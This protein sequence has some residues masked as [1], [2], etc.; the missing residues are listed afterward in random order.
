MDAL[1]TD[2]SNS[3]TSRDTDPLNGPD[4]KRTQSLWRR[5]FAW[6][7]YRY[8]Y[9]FWLFAVCDAA[10][11]N[12]DLSVTILTPDAWEDYIY[13]HQLKSFIS[14]YTLLTG[15]CFIRVLIGAVKAQDWM[16][17]LLLVTHTLLCAV[18]IDTVMTA[19]SVLIFANG[20]V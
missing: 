18:Y 20:L 1:S 7:H 4:P 15:Y 11:A 2:Q 9:L 5:L 10:F 13:A 12:T 17:R 3:V 19:V 8:V 14:I 16:I 6:R